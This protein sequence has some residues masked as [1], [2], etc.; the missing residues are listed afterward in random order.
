MDKR[1]AIIIAVAVTWMAT[2]VTI[3]HFGVKWGMLIPGRG[4]M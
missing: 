1:S 4:A 2:T 3:L